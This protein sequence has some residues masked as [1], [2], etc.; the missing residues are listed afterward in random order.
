MAFIYKI[1]NK[2]NNKAYIGL[3]LRTIE[4][5]WSEH[6]RSINTLDT[7]LYRAIKK[8]GIE[9]FEV[10][11]IEEISEDVVQEREKYWIQYY[12]TYGN[13]YNATLGGEGTL[14]FH[15]TK[16]EVQDYFNKKYTYDDIARIKNCNKD[17]I[18]LAIRQLGFDFR[19]QK[20]KNFVSCWKNGEWVKDFDS[21]ANAARWLIQEGY[22]FGSV[23][24]ASANIMRVCKGIRSYAY[25]FFWEKINGDVV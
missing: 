6:K 23:D 14:T 17:T 1:T 24:S 10:E 18:S 21:A 12:G 16:E 3:T 7:P 11:E 13:G 2:I 8:Y 15:F 4:I 19:G 25:G 5:R 20:Q 9:N 22:S